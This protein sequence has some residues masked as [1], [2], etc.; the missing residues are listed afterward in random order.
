MLEY[1]EYDEAYQAFFPYCLPSSIRHDFAPGALAVTLESV[2]EF[3]Q[4]MN[5]II[6]THQLDPTQPS[7]E[8]IQKRLSLKLELSLWKSRILA[9]LAVIPTL[10]IAC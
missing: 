2:A 10:P 5:E 7:Y 4:V 1:Y 9:L 6:Q 3:G 8:E